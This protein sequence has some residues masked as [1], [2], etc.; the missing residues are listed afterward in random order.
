MRHLGVRARRRF[1]QRPGYDPVAQAESG[2]LSLNGHPDREPVRAGS[3]V[4]D[5]STAMMTCNAILGALLA[6][7]RH[8]I[9]QYVETALFDDAIAMTGQYGMNFLMTGE[10]QERF[11]NGSKTAEPLGVFYCD[12][13][14]LYVACANDRTYQRLVIDV[15]GVPELADHPDY[16]TNSQRIANAPALTA[17]LKE[18]F[19]RVGSREATLEKARRAGVPMGLV[20]TIEEGFTSPEIMAR[21]MLSE[22]RIRRQG[23]SRTSPRPSASWERRWPILS[24]RRC[25]DSI[26]TRLLAGMLGSDQNEI[27]RLASQGAF[28][29]V[30]E[31]G[32]VKVA[33]GGKR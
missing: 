26:A 11:G 10:N 17:R 20:R 19:L 18:A 6:R 21:G 4:I 12:D 24:R 25:S 1:S 9:G 22:I 31:P 32:A 5:I 8:G 2:F 23:K 33:A 13:G 30:E 29:K 16:R 3:S 28:G 7:E 27:E 15:L 14:P